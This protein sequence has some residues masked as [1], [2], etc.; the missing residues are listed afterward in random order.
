MSRRRSLVPVLL[1]ALVACDGGQP[2]G[3][4]SGARRGVAA[5]LETLAS[6]YLRFRRGL[7]REGPET[8]GVEAVPELAAALADD[9]TS[10]ASG[11]AL[12][13]AGIGPAAREAIPALVAGVGHDDWTV[14]VAAVEALTAIDPGDPAVWPA[15][16]ARVSD[17]DELVRH[18]V[19]TAL[20][21][22]EGPDPAVVAALDAA[23][24]DAD[25]LVAA[26]ALDAAGEPPPPFPEPRESP[27]AIGDPPYL[28]GAY[29]YTWFPRNWKAGYVW[30][31]LD[32]HAGP[33]L[34]EYRI[35]DPG[36]VPRHV[37]WSAR[38]G[39]D[40]WAVSWWP[41]RP[42]EDRELA[43]VL[44]AR[45]I[46]DVRFC[47]H[48][49][50]PGLGMKHGYLGMTPEVA[51]AFQEDLVHLARTYFD[52]PG[53]LRVEG[54]PV[55]ILYVARTWGDGYREVLDGARERL[56]ALG[57]DVY[58]VG[59]EVFW[60]VQH[61]TELVATPNLDRIAAFDAITPYNMYEGNEVRQGGWRGLPV[62]L[63]EVRA[64][65][66]RYRDLAAE[67]GVRFVPG[68]LAGYNDRA[69][70]PN[71]DR[72]Q[73]PRQAWPGGEEGSTLSLALDRLALPLVSTTRCPC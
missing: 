22:I 14:R 67:A 35:G 12:I 45:N 31:F 23:R 28:V 6:P 51:E 63:R 8:L 34:G 32:P 42:G 33:A 62:Y 3:P 36:V 59:D 49:E 1:T 24:R 72:Y 48:Y 18:R 70:R 38:H 17:P 19:A 39:I 40:F 27:R 68:V 9:R 11:A 46:G 64:L 55:V 16:V 29:Y 54:R 57:H 4:A 43:R 56:S 5:E 15:L 65:Y 30:R 21:A 53:Y 66:E 20:A 61:G 7:I 60:N 58:L 44:R 2:V 26:V 71:L 73:I 50:S 37:R 13:L 69:L 41:D 47:I 52:H 25:R 10:I